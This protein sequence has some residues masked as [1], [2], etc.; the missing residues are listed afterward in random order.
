MRSVE[1]K[2]LAICGGF[3]EDDHLAAEG[4]EEMHILTLQGNKLGCAHP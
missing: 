4:I 2:A 1:L 3:D